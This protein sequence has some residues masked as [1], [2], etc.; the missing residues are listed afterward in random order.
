MSC[1]ARCR[2]G[3]RDSWARRR[4]R[5]HRRGSAPGAAYGG[6][7]RLCHAYLRN[8]GSVRTARC[9]C[10]PEGGRRA[11]W[12]ISR[13]ETI[14]RLPLISGTSPSAGSRRRRSSWKVRPCGRFCCNWPWLAMTFCGVPESRSSLSSRWIDSASGA[15][16]RGPAFQVGAAG[17]GVAVLPGVIGRQVELAGAARNADAAAD[18]HEPV[19]LGQRL[20]GLAGQVVERGEVAIELAHDLVQHASAMAGLP[21]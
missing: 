17:A 4:C 15:S 1:S 21:R 13:T 7:L 19:V 3:G 5:R 11:S 2:T 6:L 16:V 9:R 18:A 14:S 8:K 10:W 20:A 12:R